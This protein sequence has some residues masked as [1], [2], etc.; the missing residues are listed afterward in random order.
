MAGAAGVDGGLF[1]PDGTQAPPPPAAFPDPLA[2]LV[3]GELP[4][5]L[6][7]PEV[8]AA[9][10]RAAAPLAPPAAVTP[11]RAARPTGAGGRPQ[12]GRARTGQRAPQAPRPAV[13]HPPVPYPPAS[14]PPVPHPTAPYPQVPH[15]QL[16]HLAPP[17]RQVPGLRAQRGPAAPAQPAEAL[18]KGTG[19]TVVGILVV[20]GVIA[21]ILFTTLREV[22]GELLDLLR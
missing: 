1:G 2:G 15:P 18:A 10:V 5:A 6:P 8:R 19:S 9:E 21:S 13:P 3:T 17:P 12:A 22:V 14:Y 11:Q 7:A 16:Q 4:W 20:F